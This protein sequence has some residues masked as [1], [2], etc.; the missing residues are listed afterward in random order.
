MKHQILISSLTSPLLTYLFYPLTV[1]FHTFDI[2]P[3]TRK[4]YDNWLAAKHTFQI[5]KCRDNI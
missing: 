1:L 2:R 5:I 4:Q 3:E